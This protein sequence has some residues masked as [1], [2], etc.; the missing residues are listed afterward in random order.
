MATEK[1][2]ADQYKGGRETREAQNKNSKQK[3]MTTIP[4]RVTKETLRRKWNV[5][6]PAQRNM[7]QKRTRSCV[8]GSTQKIEKEEK[9]KIII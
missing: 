4:K 9:S 5:R 2:C 1:L 8:H 6:N 7:H 3:Q